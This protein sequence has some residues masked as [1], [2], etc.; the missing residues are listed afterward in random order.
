MRKNNT[1]QD[2]SNNNNLISLMLKHKALIKLIESLNHALL[3]NL[4][5]IAFPNYRRFR[6]YHGTS[7][8]ITEVF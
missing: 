8:L 5:C 3:T 2:K 1:K 7:S 6:Q 4:K